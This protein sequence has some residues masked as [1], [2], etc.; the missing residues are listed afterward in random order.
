M[1][2]DFKKIPFRKSTYFTPTNGRHVQVIVIHSMEAPEKGDT[3]ENIAR[4]FASSPPGKPSAHYCID[5]TSIVQCVQTKDV[6]N[7]APGCNHNGIQLEHAGYARQTEDQWLD[8]YSTKMLRLSAE[9][10]GRILCP[11]YSIPPVFLNANALRVANEKTSMK[12]FTTHAEVSRAFKRS[13][14]W[15]PGPEFPMA[16]YLEWVKEYSDEF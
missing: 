2:V 16:E 15:D 9:L 13:S 5:N 10:C 11:K 12:G 4:Y 14:H 8:E 6:A 1:S 3:A 7:A